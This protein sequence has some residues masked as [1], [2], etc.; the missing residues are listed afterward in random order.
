MTERSAAP[1]DQTFVKRWVVPNLGGVVALLLLVVVATTSLEFSAWALAAGAWLFNRL[2]HVATLMFVK[3]FPPTL[4]VGA[5]GFGMMLRVWVVTFGLFFV[6]ADLHIGGTQIGLDHPD[7]AV[8]AMLMFLVLFTVD[9]LSR[10]AMTLR[11][12]ALAQN[13][14][15]LAAAEEAAK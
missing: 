2:G 11:D 6:G 8:P 13:A 5:A 9:M 14:R 15:N 3:G 12:Q 1:A 10:V 7:W 4:A